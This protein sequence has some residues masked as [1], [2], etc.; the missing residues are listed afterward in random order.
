MMGARGG[1]LL[2]YPLPAY[3]KFTGEMAE[4]FKILTDS[5]VSKG[6]EELLAHGKFK[7]TFIEG[8]DELKETTDFNAPDLNTALA[9]KVR[10]V[11]ADTVKPNTPS[12]IV[13]FMKEMVEICSNYLAQYAEYNKDKGPAFKLLVKAMKAKGSQQLYTKGKIK[14]T[15]GKAATDLEEAK[16]LESDHDDPNLSQEIHSRLSKLVEGQVPQ[17]LKNDMTDTLDITSKYLSQSAI[18]ELERGPAFD[19]LIKELQRNG[20]DPFTPQF[21]PVST[22]FAGSY[23]LKSAPGLSSIEPDATTAPIFLD[24][25]HRSVDAATPKALTNDMNEVIQRCANYLSAFVRDRDI[26][27]QILLKMMKGN[28]SKDLAQRNNYSTNYGTGAAETEA[29]PI[30]IPFLPIKDIAD[31]VK[32]KISP[33]AEKVTPPK[34]KIAMK[35]VVQDVSRYLSQPTALR[36]GAAGDR[37]PLNLLAAVKQSLGSRPLFKFKSFGQTYADAADVL[38]YAGPLESDP[39]QKSENLKAEIMTEMR[40][41]VPQRL[42]P[43]ITTDLKGTMDE[44]ATH[45]AKIGMEKGEALQYLVNLMKEQGEAPLAQLQGY[46]QTYNDGARR[47]EVAPSLANEKVDKDAYEDVRGKFNTLVDAKPAAEHKKHMPGIIEDASKFLAKPMPET[48]AEKRQILADLMTRQGDAVLGKEDIY[49]VT[50]T[51]GGRELMKAPVGVTNSVDDNK[52]QEISDKIATVIPDKKLEVQ[53]KDSVQEGSA[54]I[55]DILKG[56][57]EVMKAIH[58]GMK[59]EKDKEF[60]NIGKFS[61]SHGETADMLSNASHFGGQNPSPVI[62]DKVAPLVND[63]ISAKQ[64]SAKA[65]PYVTETTNITT[66]YIAGIATNEC[67]LDAKALAELDAGKARSQETKMEQIVSEGSRPENTETEKARLEREKSKTGTNADREIARSVVLEVDAEREQALKIL[68]GQLKAKGG[69]TFY[70]QPHNHLTHNQAS[71]WLLMNP[72]MVV[73][74]S[75][76]ESGDTSRLHKKFERKL[77]TLVATVTP[78]EMYDT[79][80]DV[81]IESSRILSEYFVTNSYKALVRDALIS[82]MQKRRNEILIEVNGAAETYFF[83]AQRLKKV[84]SLEVKDPSPNISYFLAKNLEEIIRCHSMARKL[85]AAMKDHIKEASDFLSVLVTKPDEQIEAYAA[86]LNEMEAAGD[87]LLIE[88]NIPKTYKDSAD[89]LRHLTSYKD[90]YG[91]S[92]SSLQSSTE[93]KLKQ[94]MAHVKSGGYSEAALNGTITESTKLLVSYIV[95]QGEKTEVLKEM[96]GHMDHVGGNVLLR[97]GKIRKTYSEGADLLRPKNADQLSVPGADPVVS[98]KIQI[99]LRNLMDK[100]PPK[101]H[102]ELVDAVIEDATMFMAIH[103]LE[104]QII[105]VCKCMKNVF[106][107]CELWCD[108]ILRRVAQPCCSCSRHVSTQALSDVAPGKKLQVCP[109]TSRAHESGINLNVSQCPHHMLQKSP[110]PAHKPTIDC[111][112]STTASYLLY[113]PTF[114]HFYPYK[115]DNVHT[116]DTVPI[117]GEGSLNPNLPSGS[118]SLTFPAD[119]SSSKTTEIDTDSTLFSYHT[120]QSHTPVASKDE[121]AGPFTQSSYAMFFETKP[122]RLSRID[123]KGTSRHNEKISTRSYSSRTPIV[124]TDEMADWHAMMV[125]LIWNLQA[126]RDWI[127]DNINRALYYYQEQSRN[128]DEPEESWLTFQ[129]RVTTEA[130]QWRQ[131]NKFSRQLTMRL[132]LRYQG[133]EIL[134]PTRST[135]ATD[136]YIECQQDTLHIIEMFNKWTQWITVLLKETDSMQQESRESATQDMRWPHFREKVQEHANDWAVY[137]TYLDEC[138]QKKYEQII[139]AWKQPGPVWVVSA[140]G[141]VPSGAVAAGVY[142]GEVIW[143]A[144]TTHRSNVLPA[145]LHPSKHCCVLYADGGVH[146][147]TKYQVMCNAEVSW[148]AWRAGD[149]SARTVRVASGVHVGRVHYRGSHLLGAVQAP[150]YRCHVLIYGR[151]FAFSC[152]DLLVLNEP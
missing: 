125:S 83:A 148:V 100:N 103:F 48:P 38:K 81:I 17:D 132:A 22:K 30:L 67:G 64:V 124:T 15:N 35:A 27:L 6:N 13:P 61:K 115:R 10:N 135:V 5:M 97:H 69:E 102:L 60:L 152:Y 23:V 109:G 147:Y 93:G 130:L 26:A 25:L 71:E 87:T 122:Q 72:P 108:E 141:A 139:S 110:C 114:S 96:I 62:V 3:L 98:R 90:K 66:N 4:A 85:M 99:K 45:L 31:E 8:A 39:T 134:S 65:K 46:Q 101:K 55:T 149:V 34:L 73:D 136:T 111:G 75:V 41:G 28:A 51:E 63:I 12:N 78:E 119:L 58:D 120:P 123:Y 57:G 84:Q 133:R 94:L 95:L 151:P 106:V 89:F 47:I 14:K 91:R 77:S 54:Y 20:G 82:G 40:R 142:E 140:C 79:M 16:G 76:K 11:L 137:N 21:A 88:T 126:W 19:L 131:Y 32:Q 44:A 53:L 33:D 7:M 43:S 52:K 145:A 70:K 144:R 129:R 49:K 36:S 50:Y 68:H 118:P 112:R 138:W 2:K 117:T 113:S 18:D 128:S 29:A 116:D 42:A 127:Q 146:H 37:Y 74:R 150:A 80:Q 24:V 121:S 9:S 1:G 104:P 92:D 105:Q 56:R 59:S 143:V 107:Q 86:L